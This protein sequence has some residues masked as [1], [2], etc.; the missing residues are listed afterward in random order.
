MRRGGLL[1]RFIAIC[2]SYMTICDIW[3]GKSE[4]QRRTR[5]R[6]TR[7]DENKQRRFFEGPVRGIWW[8]AFSLG[9]WEMVGS[10]ALR[11]RC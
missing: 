6:R 2:D 5:T 9:G 1:D 4:S 8:V 3:Q 11:L 7:T 10:G